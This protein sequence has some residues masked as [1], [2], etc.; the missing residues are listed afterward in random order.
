MGEQQGDVYQCVDLQADV[1]MRLCM[2]I[3]TLYN[4]VFVHRMCESDNVFVLYFVWVCV[5][6]NGIELCV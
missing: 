4:F 3:A 5:R 6:A 1:N 2:I